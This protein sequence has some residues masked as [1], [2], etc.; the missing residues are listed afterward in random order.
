MMSINLFADPHTTHFEQWGAQLIDVWRLTE[1]LLQQ[2]WKVDTEESDIMQALSKTWRREGVKVWLVLASSVC[3]PPHDEQSPIESLC[4]YRF[5]PATLPVRSIYEETYAPGD[6]NE[7]WFAGHFEQHGWIINNGDSN[8]G[9]DHLMTATPL[10]GIPAAIRME[11]QAAL[12]AAIRTAPPRR[13][14]RLP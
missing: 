8:T 13:S 9:D 12:S 7:P 5:K 11:V 6:E 1:A 14:G 2:G 10:G 4:F 3:A